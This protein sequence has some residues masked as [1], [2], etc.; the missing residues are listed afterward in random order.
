V[1]SLTEEQK[2]ILIGCLLG[3]GAMRKKKNA[4]LEI[5]H[6]FAQ[7]SLVDW[8]LSKFAGLV[9][10][11]PKKRNGNGNRVAYRFVTRSLPVLTPFYDWFFLNKK[12]IIPIDLKLTPLSIAVWFM[13]DGSKSYSSVYLNTQQFTMDEQRN[14]IN[15]L[16]EQFGLESRLNKEKTYFRIRLLTQSSKKFVN[17]I[18]PYILKEFR[19]KLPNSNLS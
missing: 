10:T 1:G 18:E 2:S 13:D 4:L 12:K 11:L 7:K 6:C 16:R 5:N 9:N 8:K 17:L 14:L 19:Y 15:C 3:D